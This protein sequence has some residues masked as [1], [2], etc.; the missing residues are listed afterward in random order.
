MKT[1][2]AAQIAGMAAL[3]I[4]F[5]VQAASADPDYGP[6]NLSAIAEAQLDASE[7]EAD[8]RRECEFVGRSHTSAASLA[9]YQ[10]QVSINGLWY[11]CVDSDTRARR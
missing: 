6:G 7:Y 9:S 8:G 3:A 5:A 4:V 10:M 11:L 1:L 2:I